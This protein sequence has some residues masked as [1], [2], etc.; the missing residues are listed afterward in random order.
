MHA[1]WLPGGV[2]HRTGTGAYLR[3]FAGEW[4]SAGIVDPHWHQGGSGRVQ[5]WCLSVLERVSEAPSSPA[6]ALIRLAS[7]SP[8]HIV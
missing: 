6:D 5:K 2:E 3:T 7:E 8:S 1:C 4:E